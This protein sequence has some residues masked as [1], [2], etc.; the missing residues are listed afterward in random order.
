MVWITFIVMQG[1][2]WA[3]KY[4]IHTERPA[5]NHHLTNPG[6][7][8]GVAADMG[9]LATYASLLY[10][11]YWFL[12]HSVGISISLLRLYNGAHYWTDVVGGYFIGVV[13]IQ[14]MKKQR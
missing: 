10:P 9:F 7:P 13:V 1:V 8:S 2:V 5:G 6:F 14:I 11:K 3:I 4:L 12:W